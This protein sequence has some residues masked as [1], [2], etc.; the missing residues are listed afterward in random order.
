MIYPGWVKTGITSRALNPD[1][2]PRGSVASIEDGA[3]PVEDCA[4]K[5]LLAVAKRKRE[6]V[7]LGRGK[8]GRWLRVIA[9]GLIDR[10]IRRRTFG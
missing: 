1:G 10:I 8:F 6:A 3:M 7:M 4:Q 2:T 9:P 5:I